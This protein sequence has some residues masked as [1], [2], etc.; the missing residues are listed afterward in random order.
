MV[1]FLMAYSILTFN[2]T[3]YA[4]VFT[5]WPSGDKGNKNNITDVEQLVNVK[6]VWSEP[7]NINGIDLEL[8]IAVISATAEDL[9]MQINKAFT[10]SAIAANNNTMLIKT[11]LND[12]WE[13]RTLLFFPGENLPIIMFTMNT[14]A[15]FPA[16]LIWP[17]NLPITADGIPLKYMKFHK[18]D[19]SYG[20]YKTPSQPAAA[21][22]EISVKLRGDGWTSFTGEQNSTNGGSGEIFFKNKPKSLMLVNFN[23]NGVATVITRPAK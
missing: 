11:K 2:F 19:A 21:L 14:P 3:L 8:N 18:R 20:E 12:S 17:A 4:D 6:T 5:L 23:T 10:D 1:K 13:R 9:L 22:D 16:N 7:V 15:T